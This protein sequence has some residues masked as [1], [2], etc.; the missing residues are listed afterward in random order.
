MKDAVEVTIDGEPGKRFTVW[1][2][3]I[4]NNPYE[5]EG[6]YDSI[7]EVLRHKW[8]LDRRYKIRVQGKFLTLREFEKWAGSNKNYG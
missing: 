2:T 8:R 5:C 6:K 7:V 3:D 4:D 1:R